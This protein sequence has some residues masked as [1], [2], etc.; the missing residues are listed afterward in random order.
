MECHCGAAPHYFRFAIGAVRWFGNDTKIG[1]NGGN[2]NQRSYRD[3]IRD[4]A[5]L[6]HSRRVRII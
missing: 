1:G 5:S 3:R 2:C 6:L 4:E